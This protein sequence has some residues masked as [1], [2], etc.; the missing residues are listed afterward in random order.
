[1]TDGD[2]GGDSVVHLEVQG[3]YQVVTTFAIEASSHS[4]ESSRLVC[5]H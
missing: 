2:H 1:M 4:Y 3:D 5:V